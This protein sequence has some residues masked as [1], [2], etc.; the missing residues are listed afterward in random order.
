MKRIHFRAMGSEVMGAIDSDSVAA[1]RRLELLPEWFRERELRLSRFLPDSELSQLNAA[2]GRPYR[3]GP[4]L[5]DA[6]GAALEAARWSE[7]LVTPTVLDAL[8]RAGYDRSF[9]RLAGTGGQGTGAGWRGMSRRGP[10]GSPLACGSTWAAR[11]RE[12]R[13]MPRRGGSPRRVPPWWMRE[14]TWR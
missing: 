2:A 3:A 13:R 14:G 9:E 11:P 10:S 4:V 6:V 7:G 12:E 8:E 5:W 1:A